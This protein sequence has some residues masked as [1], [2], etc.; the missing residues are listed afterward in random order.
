MNKRDFLK[1]GSVLTGAALLTKFTGCSPKKTNTVHLKNWAGN[2]E[3][4]T[5]NVHYPKT[6]AEVQEAVK[7]CSKLRPLGSKH[8]FNTI[9]DS[10]ENLVS[11]QELNKVVSLDKQA[12]TV[13]VEGGI[14]Y[15]ELAP[16][17]QTNGFALHNLASLPH[18]SVAGAVSTATHG[19]GVQN[20]NLSTQVSAI[21][22]VN[23]AG[24]VV[25]LS[26]QKDGEQ[27]YGAV[28]GLGAL[29]LV[30]KL[31]L[32]IIPTFEMQQVVY[33]NLPMQE[34]EKNFLEIMSGGYSVSLFTDWRNKNVSEV[35]VKSKVDGKAPPPELFGAKLATQN[36]HPI[37]TESAENCTAQLGVPGHWYERMPH[38]KM[39][40]KPSSGK[41]L[42][43]EFF[44]P[45]ENAFPAMMAMEQLGSQ[46]S[47]HLF[48]SEIRTVQADN[49]WMSPAYKQTCAVLHTTWKQE[50]SEVMGL[51]PKIEAALAPYNPRPHWAKLFTMPSATLQSRYAKMNDFKQLISE[52]DPAGKFK[53][54]FISK[55][56]YGS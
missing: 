34:L 9:A 45:V 11:T 15:G 22:F 24:D 8:S 4:S 26:K 33:R 50:V 55:N 36:L 46:I 21:E 37:E 47:P 44:V 30:T 52:Y 31:T 23:A 5:G 40:F 28:V 38:F 43:S 49:F 32:D 20:G 13:T 39:G 56:I 53:N 6:V 1:A 48:I 3:Y 14:K 19:S 27:F 35:W 10:T 7:K 12:S 42:Q 51:I 18:I 17:L 2:L 54:G 29:G 41:E 16:Y 25:N